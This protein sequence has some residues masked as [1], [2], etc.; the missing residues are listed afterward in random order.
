MNSLI[1]VKRGKLTLEFLVSIFHISCVHFCITT[2]CPW[3]EQLAYFDP[4]VYMSY[5]DAKILKLF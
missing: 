4:Y 2:N 5:P 3:I 1:Q